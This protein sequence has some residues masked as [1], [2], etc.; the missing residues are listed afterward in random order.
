MKKLFLL[1]VTFIFLVFFTVSN[2]QIQ[3]GVQ[4]GINLT[5]VKMELSQQGFE[6]AMR[7][8]AI[9]GGILTYN[10]SP[11]IALQFE[12][13][14]VQ[15]GATVNF[16]A[17]ESGAI[18]DIEASVSANYFDLPLLL[19]VSLP[20]GPIKPYLL[21]GGSIAFLLGDAKMKVEKASL[22]GLDVTPLI[23]AELREQTLDLKK[24]DY[25]LSVGAGVTFPLTLFELFLEGRYDLGLGNISNEGDENEFKT[26]GF[27]I[28]AGLLFSL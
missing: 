17:E 21:A 13:A 20:Y 11:V 4:A 7:T 19:K 5:N 23:P 24:Q 27:Q 2:A 12:P 16:T 9:V 15:K 18:V 28:K 26:T 14:Y 22:G 10:F 6:T 1:S 3:I 8:R 25:I